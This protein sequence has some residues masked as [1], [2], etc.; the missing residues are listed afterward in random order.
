[1]R[2]VRLIA[3][4]A[5]HAITAAA[6]AGE[7][8]TSQQPAAALTRQKFLAHA[9]RNDPGMTRVTALDRVATAVDGAESSHGADIGMWRADPSGPQGPMQVSEAAATDA[10]GVDRFDLTQ[11]RAIGR[12]YL[13]QLYGRYR[14]WPD[15]IAAYNWGRGRMDAWV[16]AGRPSDKFL[17][18][19]AIYLRRVLQESGLCA[20][21]VRPQLGLLS[22]AAGSRNRPRPATGNDTGDPEVWASSVLSPA[23]ATSAACSPPSEWIP[24]DGVGRSRF[25][26]KLDQGLQLAVQRS[27]RGP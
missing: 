5:A 12:A 6:V 13:A 25:V 26:N 2:R 22:E 23:S 16:R 7:H 19:V 24:A 9:A 21:S 8:A 14:N 20:G 18:T 17:A 1:M 3:L 11:N 27:L 10:G 4:L 15:A